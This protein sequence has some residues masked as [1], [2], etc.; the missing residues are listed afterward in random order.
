MTSSIDSII[1]SMT[2][3]YAEAPAPFKV[4]ALPKPV[5]KLAAV[6]LAKLNGPIASVE[7]VTVKSVA[8]PFEVPQVGTLNADQF[9][10]AM[11]D[12]GART[13]QAFNE[14]TQQH[15]PVVK[16]DHGEIRHDQIKAIAGFI[17]Y[18]FA[19]NFGAQ[20]L[21]A[22][23]QANAAIKPI[24]AGKDRTVRHIVEG[25]IAGMP[26]H[27][28]KHILNLE[29]QERLT[30]ETLVDHLKAAMNADSTSAKLHHET[31]AQVERERLASI[32]KDLMSL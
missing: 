8:K 10:L 24:V 18:N 25:Y 4:T 5:S 22:R 28:A 26:D 30:V 6:K 2:G 3:S 9:I 15:Y 16:I 11:R 1:A 20:D 31:L 13:F 21:R 32:R 17:G 7:P 29:A 19:E 23:L 14:V 27:K 12:A